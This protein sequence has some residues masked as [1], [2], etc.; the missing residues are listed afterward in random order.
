[1]I[2]ALGIEAPRA[3][4]ITIAIGVHA[5]ILAAGLWASS[6][7]PSAEPEAIRIAL[8]TLAPEPEE[9]SAPA[10]EL[11]PEPEPEPVREPEPLPPPPE[12]APRPEPAPDPVPA[13]PQPAP[14]AQPVQE[15]VL[16]SSGAP[17]VGETV[18]AA[19]APAPAKPAPPA[20]PK[21][22]ARKA[23][24]FGQ[25][26]AWLDRH[27]R[28]PRDARRNRM[29]GVS[30]L[31]ISIDRSG[32]VREYRLVSGSG[33]EMLDEASLAMVRRADPLPAMPRE[34]PGDGMEFVV[35]VEFFMKA[36]RR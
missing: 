15:T 31:F 12:P 16:A 19:A 8:A 10:P 6:A 4:G 32:R 26:L 24:Y 5:A 35:P 34:V 30:E 25:I 17:E 20:D 14:T 28:Y 7:A 2:R 11:L 3:A 29:E 33:H 18:V 1:M 13:P 27:K 22:Q 9:E 21:A 36:G 23:T